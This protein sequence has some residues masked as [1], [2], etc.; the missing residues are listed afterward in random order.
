[1]T[2]DEAAQSEPLS[3]IDVIRAF[4]DGVRVLWQMRP[5]HHRDVSI[6]NML[7]RDST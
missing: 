7:L 5:L 6:F 2:W 4:H 1:M 3:V